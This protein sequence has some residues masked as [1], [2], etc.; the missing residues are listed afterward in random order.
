MLAHFSGDSA[1]RAAFAQGVDIHTAVAAEV[2]GIA[3]E[4]VDG[5]MRRVAK[6]VNFGVIYGQ[7]PFGLAAALGI[8]QADAAKFIDGY[9]A[10][11]EGVDRYLASLLKKCTQS[12]YATTI[13]GRRRAIRGIRPKSPPNRQR[14]LPERTAINTVIQGSAADL[15]KQAMLKVFDRMQREDHPGRI[16]LQIHDELVLEAPAERIAD[17]GRLVREEMENA[18]HLEVPLKVDVSAGSDWL[19]AEPFE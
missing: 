16:L 14:N 18:L 12:G 4:A 6:A 3:P 10:R 13:L 1:L 2:Y 5:E 8:S 11:Y 15:I 7:S 9:F 19:N 17:L